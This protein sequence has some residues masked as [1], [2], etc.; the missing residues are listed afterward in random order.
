MEPVVY[1]LKI[2]AC[3]EL[4]MLGQHLLQPASR[5]DA[6]I[7]GDKT[8]NTNLGVADL[9][10]ERTWGSLRVVLGWNAAPNCIIDFF[11]IPVR[12][13]VPELVG[14]MTANPDKN[15]LQA[16]F[17]WCD[18]RS[19]FEI[20]EDSDTGLVQTCAA[21]ENPNMHANR[22][23]TDSV[24]TLDLLSKESRAKV[25]QTLAR[26][27]N[28][29]TELKA[30]RD[31]IEKPGYYQ[32]DRK[33]GVAHIFQVQ[34]NELVR[35]AEWF[36]N[37]RLESHA[38]AL[39]A[40]IE[41][42]LKGNQPTSEQLHAMAN[43]ALYLDAIGYTKA[44][45]AGCWEEIPFPGGLTWD[46]EAGR[47]AFWELISLRFGRPDVW[48]DLM[49]VVNELY[50][51]Y[52]RRLDEADALSLLVAKGLKRVRETYL[53]EAPE[54]RERDAALVFV[55]QSADL[56]L[57]EDSLKDARRFHELLMSLESSLVR[58]QGM[59][60]Y[61][62]F[63]LE[64]GDAERLP[65][66]YLACNYWLALDETGRL[67]PPRTRLVQ[68]FGS[69]DA[70]DPEVFRAR[71]KLAIP[72]REA[73]WFMVSDLSRAWSRQVARVRHAR[74]ASASANMRAFD[75]ME[76]LAQNHAILNLYRALGRI[77][78][79]GG[80]KSNGQPCP[81]WSVPE[82]WEWVRVAGKAVGSSEEYVDRLLPGVNTPLAWAQASLKQ[83]ILALQEIL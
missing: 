53:A 55:A 4:E 37:A 73:E 7:F 10:S 13:N 35:D 59:I 3:T 29:P 64:P 19:V 40:F 36:N 16:I 48:R 46:T 18:I 54:R 81:H 76:G 2:P 83:A 38:L 44:P 75:H 41:H 80:V 57:D 79:P 25:L 31:C 69:K 11:G 50:P 51:G 14:Y 82:A 47:A 56:I 70:S 65:D 78:G 26:F 20:K 45:S 74:K 49:R 33:N 58:Q 39:R 23:I 42:V 17:E 68:E 8:Y 66:S 52:D 15:Q 12:V 21:A 63:R 34:G 67:N 5:T 71:C 61:T 62:P 72:N 32:A 6:W 1:L 9:A 77:T 28:T 24:R 27:Y 30:F 60:R 43:L 22:W